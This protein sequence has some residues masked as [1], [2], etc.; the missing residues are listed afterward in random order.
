MDNWRDLVDFE[1][2]PV[3]SSAEVRAIVAPDL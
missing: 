3:H 2:L 1:V